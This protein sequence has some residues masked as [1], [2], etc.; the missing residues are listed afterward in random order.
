MH[1]YIRRIGYGSGNEVRSDHI[2]MKND[3][4]LND[5]SLVI[6]NALEQDL[7]N[8]LKSIFWNN[9]NLHYRVLD[10][11][12]RIDDPW[13]YVKDLLY[14]KLQKYIQIADLDCNRGNNFFLNNVAYGVHTDYYNTE[15]VSVLIPLMTKNDDQTII[16][17]DQWMDDEPDPPHTGFSFRL[18][19][20]SRL[21]SNA[22]L[23]GKIRDFP[24]MNLTNNNI[25][26]ILY[27]HLPKRVKDCSNLLHGLSG[28]IIR[29]KPGNVIVF[30]SRRLHVTGRTDGKTRLA[31]S[32]TFRI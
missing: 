1:R 13:K 2:V 9:M 32:L 19:N 6:E 29:W 22:V 12:V 5:P 15:T 4:L 30:N 16:I 17:F 31:L 18:N 7:I 10:Y 25:P 26:D 21:R 23:N 27:V 24:V 3:Y 20:T 14:C 28:N 8:D 11:D